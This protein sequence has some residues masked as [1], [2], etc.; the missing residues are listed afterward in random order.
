MVELVNGWVEANPGSLEGPEDTVL[1][2][3][4]ATP[5]DPKRNFKSDAISKTQGRPPDERTPLVGK[6]EGRATATAIS[7]DAGPLIAINFPG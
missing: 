5:P 2:R 7:Q 6:K 3:F 4:R 1:K